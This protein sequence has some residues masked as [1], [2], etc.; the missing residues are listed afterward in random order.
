MAALIG[1]PVFPQGSLSGVKLV[2]GARYG[3]EP[4]LHVPVFA[5]EFFGARKMGR[6]ALHP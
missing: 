4:R 6:A 2:A 1:Q 5:M 3:V